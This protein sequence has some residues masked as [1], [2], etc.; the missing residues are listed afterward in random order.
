MS[1][2]SWWV[3]SW[4]VEGLPYLFDTDDGVRAHEIAWR[5]AEAGRENVH[6]SEVACDVPAEVEARL[7]ERVMRAIA[8]ERGLALL[9]AAGR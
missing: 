9:E 4:D 6:V 2:S 3:V 7:R 8:A 5:M 1:D